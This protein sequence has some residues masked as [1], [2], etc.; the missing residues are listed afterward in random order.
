MQNILHKNEI[1]VLLKS[2]A[3]QVNMHHKDSLPE[4]GKSRLEV[5]NI[6]IAIETINNKLFKL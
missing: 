1:V 4:D 6:K 2:E 5:A 3:P